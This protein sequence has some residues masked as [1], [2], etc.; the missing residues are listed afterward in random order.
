MYQIGITNTPRKRLA[1]HVNRGW[2]VIEYM[3]PMSGTKALQHETNILRMLRH[4]GADLMNS[5]IAGKFD[6][7]SESWSIKSYSAKSLADLIKSSKK[8]LS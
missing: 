5:R 7:Y 4:N 6:G 8:Y 2:T 1:Q 3:G